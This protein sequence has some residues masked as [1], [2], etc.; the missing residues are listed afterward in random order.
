[1]S[2]VNSLGGGDIG[3]DDGWLED[4]TPGAARA[5]ALADE[6]PVKTIPMNSFVSQALNEA[7][8]KGGQ[9]FESVLTNMDQLVLSIL[10]EDL[11]RG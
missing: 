4:I 5:A 1:M 11:S 10:K 3:S 7:Q 6:D 8:S 2:P 9:F